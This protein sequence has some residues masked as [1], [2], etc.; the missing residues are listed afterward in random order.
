MNYSM[1]NFEKEL[2]EI[3]NSEIQKC[4][5]EDLVNFLKT[6]R[7]R[8]LHNV[9]YRNGEFPKGSI[10]KMKKYRTNYNFANDIKVKKAFISLLA[11]YHNTAI[12]SPITKEKIDYKIKSF[13]K[14]VGKQIN[15][16]NR[17]YNRNDFGV[18]S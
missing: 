8:I 7:E 3:Y 16:L 17:L 6:E 11:Y 5:N 12:I 14:K 18:V 13:Y 15:S 2:L 10:P 9:R 1:F 4:K